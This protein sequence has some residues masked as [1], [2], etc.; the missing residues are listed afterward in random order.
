MY[1][2]IKLFF[3]KNPVPSANLSISQSLEKIKMKADFWKVNKDD[4][5]KYFS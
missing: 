1:D 5:E 2:E 4:I 3:E